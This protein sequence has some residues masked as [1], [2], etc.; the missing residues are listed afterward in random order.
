MTE[1]TLARVTAYW[2]EQQPDE[3]A[4]VHENNQVSWQELEAQSNQLA[5]A[6]QSLGVKHNDFVTVALPNGIEF[7]VSC[8]AI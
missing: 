1:I 2:A 6:Y 3:I 8:I 7:F 4:L 5:R